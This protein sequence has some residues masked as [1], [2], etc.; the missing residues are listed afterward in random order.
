ML[1]CLKWSLGLH[2]AFLVALV[3][4][5]FATPSRSSRTMELIILPKGTSLDAQ[6]TKEVVDA[7]GNAATPAAAEPKASPSPSA[8]PAPSPP[9]EDP[10]ELE[11]PPL[12]V[13]TPTPVRLPEATPAPTPQ[14]TPKPEKTIT[15]PPKAS[16]TPTAT[17]KP[18]KTATPKPSP[19]PTA[20][21]GKPS[22]KTAA[23]TPKANRAKA[24]P[25]K[26]KPTPKQVGSIYDLPPRTEEE[27]LAGANL[28]KQTPA[29]AVVSDAAPG[30]EIG[31]PGVAEGVE[32]AP[33]PLDRRQSGISMLY[34][35]RARMRIQTNFT[36]PPGVDDP[37]LTCVI[38]WEILPDGTIQNARVSKST[39]TPQYDA[40]AIEA[41]NKAGNLGPL[42]PEFG[43]RSI[44]T[45]LTFIY[46]GNQ[47]LPPA[48]P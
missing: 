47:P 5:T 21:P 29:N 41:V 1:R 17:P 15:V 48:T 25:A 42:P 2:A 20:K 26:P 8:A 12:A 36:V 13:P 38:E 45:S 28:P 16:P 30:R 3:V 23:P 34:A 39:G 27:R 37:H 6:L 19:S 32:G 22:P 31:V 44:W 46:A 4:W 9:P 24:T 35:T 10:K 43:G 14:P 33:L 11:I 7:I 40:C 18:K